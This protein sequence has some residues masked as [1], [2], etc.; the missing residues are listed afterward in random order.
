LQALAQPSDLWQRFPSQSILTTAAR[1]N[2]P[3]LL[4]VLNGFLSDDTRQKVNDGLQ[5]KFGTVL[6]MDFVKDVLPCLGPDIGLCVAPN[7]DGK[8]IPDVLVALRIQSGPKDTPVDQAVVRAVETYAS[9]GIVS[10]NAHQKDTKDYLQLL[11]QQQ[12]G[13][14]VKYLTQ[15]HFPD[16][17]QPAFALKGGYL[18]LASSPQ[19]IKRFGPN[20]PKVKGNPLLHL[21]FPQLAQLLKS[22]PKWLLDRF[23]D[24]DGPAAP[25]ATGW[26]EEVV[27][28]LG[29]LDNLH[30]EQHIGSGQ[31][32]W[33]AR[34]QTAT[35]GK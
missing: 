23:S 6:G 2:A 4:D 18:V 3:A 34:L 19:A 20:A 17:F 27:E 16:G 9:L 33:T 26:L 15:R 22:Q 21:S 32:T 5:K 13:V 29:L 7:P 8:P 1:V 30:I 25:A 10:F 35:S 14:E 31:I 12:N 24:K 11:S 28:V